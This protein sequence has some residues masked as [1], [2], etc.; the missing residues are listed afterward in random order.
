MSVGKIVKIKRLI[1]D[2]GGLKEAV[3][4]M[5]GASFSYEKMQ[6][7]GGTLAALAGEFFGITGIREKCFQ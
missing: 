2:L 5:W 4:I 7:A 3:Q 1:K 6:A